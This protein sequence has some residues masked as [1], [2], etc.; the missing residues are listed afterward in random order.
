MDLVPFAEEGV[1]RRLV[2]AYFGCF[3]RRDLVGLRALHVTDG[4][5]VHFDHDDDRDAQGLADFL[6][7]RKD[8]TLAR[9]QV[10]T[11]SAP[12]PFYTF[13]YLQAW[14]QQQD[15]PAHFFFLLADAGR[16][17]VNPSPQLRAYRDLITT[18]AREF[19]TGIHPSYRSFDRP[20]LLQ[21]ECARL[22]DI[23]GQAV[24]HS[25]QHFLRLRLPET[26]RML[27]EAG[28]QHDHSMGFADR[29]GYRAGMTEAY[30]W[31][32]LENETTTELW[33]HPF[34]A[35]DVSLR[36][37]E[38]LDAEAAKEKLKEMQRLCQDWEISFT[39]LWHNSSFSHLHGWQGWQ[40][41]YESLF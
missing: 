12:D 20:D 8:L 6:K 32:D 31:Y 24:R 19:E 14:H 25:R 22:A 34:A 27:L 16:Y 15:C 26:Y 33:I 10:L 23:S 41:V 2:E 21:K 28:I 7:G 38:G 29:A 11:G 35:M 30:L 4:D 13:P 18:L 37:Y 9:W 1:F 3:I 39:T 5:F 36:Q 17:D 40:E